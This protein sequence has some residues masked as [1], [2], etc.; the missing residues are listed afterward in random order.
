MQYQNNINNVNINNMNFNEMNMMMN[1]PNPEENNTGEEI[2]V[3]FMNHMNII[4]PKKCTCFKNDFTYKLID[5]YDP[6][7]RWNLKKYTFNERTLYP[8]LTLEENGIKDGSVIK[9]NYAYNIIFHHLNGSR[10]V[11]TVDEDYP[12]KKAIKYFLLIIGKAGCY[13]EFY[14]LHNTNK[15]IID[16]TTPIKYIF[17]QNNL[18]VDVYS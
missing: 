7:S 1:N 12:I 9:I 3:S 8:F 18:I 10:I 17:K 2:T 15:L 5:K 14:Y 11:I 13:K 4:M 16:D 6:N